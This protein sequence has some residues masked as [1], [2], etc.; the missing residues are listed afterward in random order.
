MP[1][2]KVR[3]QISIFTESYDK[4]IQRK[5]DLQSKEK[6]ELTWDEFFEILL[7]A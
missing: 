5:L 1:E 4:L 6:R 2:D 3:T 7:E